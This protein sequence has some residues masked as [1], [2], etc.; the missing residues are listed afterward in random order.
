MVC[1][2]P[3]NC[4]IRLALGKVILLIPCYACNS[5]PLYIYNP[6]SAVPIGH[7]IY[8]PL[9]VLA[10]DSG[11]DDILGNELL[12]RYLGNHIFTLFGK[13]DDIVYVRALAYK[14]CSIVSLQVCTYKTLCPIHIEF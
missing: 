10:E 6:H 8:S 7:I 14:F 1:R 12:L 9:V 4:R 2:K 5:K 3:Q 11:I 13:D